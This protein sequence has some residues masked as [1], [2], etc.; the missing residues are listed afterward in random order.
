MP[1]KHRSIAELSP[2]TAISPVDGR[3]ADKTVHLREWFSEYAL[4]KSRLHVEIQWLIWIMKH[5]EITQLA[6]LK[7]S[8]RNFLENIAKKFTVADANTVKK[9]ESE[10][11][12]D[13]KAVE[14]FLKEVISQRKS[15]RPYLEFVHF[16]C[17]SEDINNLAYGMLLHDFRDNYLLPIQQ[18]ILDVLAQMSRDYA[19][20]A[21]LARTHG[22]PASPTTLGKE[23]A[24]FYFRLKRQVEI[25]S[26]IPILGKM[27][28]AVGNYNAHLMACP[29]FHWRSK[30]KA[31]IQSLSMQVNPC[32][33]QIESHDYL[34]EVFH[35]TTRCNLILIDL[36]RDIW[37]YVSLGYLRQ[38]PKS[39]EIGSSTMPHKVNPIDFENSEGNLITAQ[40]LFDALATKLPVSRWQR[41]LSDSTCLR[42]IGM[43]FAYSAIAYQSFL[44]GASKILPDEKL[45]RDDLNQ[46]W[47]ILGEAVQSVMRRYGLPNP[48]E[49]I[50]SITRGK[51]FDK[52]AFYACVTDLD[53]P[54]QAKKSLLQL[55]P[56]TYLGDAIK[57]AKS[58]EGNRP[59]GRKKKRV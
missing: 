47:E 26:N 59:R 55:S 51:T 16:G 8:D 40:G 52:N 6:Q 23:M 25:L 17:T 38:K 14:Y 29:A 13:V 42:S 22:Q 34:A 57:Q 12:H 28:G 2:I 18:N 35:A 37:G 33:T 36:C 50:K 9:I 44:K 27:N 54:E 49:T 7:N 10:I 11:N 1:I 43:A 58:V 56:D 39:K 31:F 5:P 45:M 3:Y 15:L 30:V 19:D 46:H 21:M 24:V 20:V 32:T 48:Y 53:I 4:I 41:D